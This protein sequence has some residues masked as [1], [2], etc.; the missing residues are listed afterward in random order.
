MRYAS[1]S[2]EAELYVSI[3]VG[4][5]RR[6]ADDIKQSEQS[7]RRQDRSAT[8]A[9]DS[10]TARSAGRRKYTP[11][12]LTALLAKQGYLWDIAKRRDGGLRAVPRTAAGGGEILADTP[13]EM[14]VILAE[15]NTRRAPRTAGGSGG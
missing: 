15:E 3:R 1:N 2:V 5:T 12:E 9:G 10:E 8:G 6:V 13:A 11:A 14:A 7:P 4:Y